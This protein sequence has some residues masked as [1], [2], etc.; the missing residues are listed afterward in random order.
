MDKEEADF[1]CQKYRFQ[2][3]EERALCRKRMICKISGKTKKKNHVTPDATMTTRQ[4]SLNC[5][6]YMVNVESMKGISI[7]SI[8]RHFANDNRR[9]LSR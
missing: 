4:V 2:F 7:D 8:S 9:Y 3:R 5:Y 6:L 1:M